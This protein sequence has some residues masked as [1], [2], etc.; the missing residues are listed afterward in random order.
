M[1]IDL[2]LTECATGMHFA[3]KASQIICIIDK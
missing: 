2:L 3:V 1:Y